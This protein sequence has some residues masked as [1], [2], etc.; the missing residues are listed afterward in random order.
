MI[1]RPPTTT[2]D[3]LA[4]CLADSGKTLAVAESCTAGA[5]AARLAAS[6]GASKWL[7]GGVI[8]Y[9]AAAKAQL[10]GLDRELMMAQGLVGSDTTAAMARGIQA[11]ATA[12]LGLAITGWAGPTGGTQTDPVGSVYVALADAHSVRVER[13]LIEGDRL[14]V[15]RG[16]VIAALELLDGHLGSNG[17][18]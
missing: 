12:S 17:E 5:L 7:W 2:L 18:G 10:L 15:Q 3:R 9:S 1:V 6:D 11:L 16:A 8:V 14:A 13:R 4:R